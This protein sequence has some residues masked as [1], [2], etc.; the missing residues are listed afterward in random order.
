LNKPAALMKGKGKMKKKPGGVK[1][2]RKKK[3]QEKKKE[4]KW[5]K[6][7]KK[8]RTICFHPW[9]GEGPEERKI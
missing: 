3:T 9:G 6:F 1:E 2:E 5:G 4:T 7:K 8:K